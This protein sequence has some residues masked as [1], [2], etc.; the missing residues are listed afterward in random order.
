MNIHELKG[1][2]NPH[3]AQVA[4]SK[5]RWTTDALGYFIVCQLCCRGQ[6]VLLAFLNK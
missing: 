3:R 6:S 2:I 5:V 1:G 4:S